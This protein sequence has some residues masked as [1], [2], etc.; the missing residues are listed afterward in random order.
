MTTGIILDIKH[1]EMHDGDGL[2]TTLFLKGCPLRCAWC[3]NPE[4]FSATPQLASYAFKC[5][6]CGTCAAV[7]PVG[8]HT[9][10]ENGHIFHREKCVACGRC[11]RVCPKNALKLFGRKVTV[12]DVLDELLADR[13]FY[14]ATGGGVTVSGGEPL[15]QSEFCTEILKALKQEGVN[16][17]VDTS[18]FVPR[19]AIEAVAP[20]TD[21]F[22]VD[23]KAMDDGVHRAYTGQSNALIFENVRALDQ[24]GKRIEAR[25]VL[26]PTVNDGLFE[27]AADFLAELKNLSA[28]KVLPYHRLA[29]AK[30]EALGIPYPLAD[31]PVPTEEER[32]RAE[33]S[34]AARGIKI[35]RD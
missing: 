5:V 30:Y 23:V 6:A 26:V 35:I 1:F 11:E 2:R 14:A 7:C 15:V 3:H 17:A 16:T 4:S 8:A 24:M 12:E 18:L 32:A 21:T 20:Y 31:V 13:S 22:L 25:M 34:L 9:V 29:L 10:G 27:A 33:E 28:V 19:A